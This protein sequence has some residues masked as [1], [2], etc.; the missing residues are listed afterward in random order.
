MQS[1]FSEMCWI[2]SIKDF[3]FNNKAVVFM[4]EP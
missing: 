4:L 1:F 3:K 2:S